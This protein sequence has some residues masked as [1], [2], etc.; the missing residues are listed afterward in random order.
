LGLFSQ[1]DEEGL[2][3][4]MQMRRDIDAKYPASKASFEDDMA[5]FLY[6]LKC[7]GPKH[8]GVGAD[9]DGGG[10]VEGLMDV[11]E[12]AMITARLLKEGYTIEQFEDIWGGNVLRVLEQARVF[13]AKGF[14]S[15]LSLN[16]WVRRSLWRCNLRRHVVT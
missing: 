6:I 11:S 10:G 3:K 4:F 16:Q 5:Q 12:L 2:S 8:F 1:L 13:C 14:L 15:L 7:I 9:W